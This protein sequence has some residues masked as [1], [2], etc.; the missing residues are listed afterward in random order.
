[1]CSEKYIA[2]LSQSEMDL[3]ENWTKWRIY[4]GMTQQVFFY[5]NFIPFLLTRM[6]FVRE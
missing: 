2:K 3:V 6:F 1:M 5:Y 4:L